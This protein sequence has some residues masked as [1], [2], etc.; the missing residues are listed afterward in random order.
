M[1]SVIFFRY[2]VGKILFTSGPHNKL[3]TIPYNELTQ[4]AIDIRLGQA[5]IMLDVSLAIIG[6]LWAVLTVRNEE[7]LLLLKEWPE[8][9]TWVLGNL[10]LIS[11]VVSYVV[12]SNKIKNIYLITSTNA[13][14]IAIKKVLDE[15]VATDSSRELLDKRLK[16]KN[17]STALQAKASLDETVR[18]INVF[19]PSINY[20]FVVQFAFLIAGIFNVGI[21]FVSAFKFKNP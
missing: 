9:T 6:I 21:A 19:G 4:A 17:D 15:A 20:L 18:I 5:G 3:E 2:V 12:Y 14:E 7:T 8:W 11:S 16:S 10:L 1:I 13:S